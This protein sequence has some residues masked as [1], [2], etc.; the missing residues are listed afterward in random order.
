MGRRTDDSVE[1]NRE[2]D[3]QRYDD[4][5]AKAEA[6]PGVVAVSVLQGRGSSTANDGLVRIQYKYVVPIYV[7]PEMKLLGLII[8]KTEL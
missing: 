3:G 5:T 1:S 2:N 4:Q 7:F 8:F 6:E